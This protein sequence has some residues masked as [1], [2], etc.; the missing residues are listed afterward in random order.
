MSRF[1]WLPAYGC[2]TLMFAA[3]GVASAPACAAEQP[4]GMRFAIPAQSLST[5]LIAFGK[6]ANVQVLTAGQTV[7]ALRSHA[8]A[9]ALSM[10]AA[11]GQLLEGTG[12][13]FAFADARTVVIKP[14]KAAAT[15]GKSNPASSL[16][17]T[18]ATLLPPIQA[19]GLVGKD[20]GF[21]ADV[22]SGPTRTVS[23]PLD[24]PQS[25]GIV[26]QDLLQSEQVQ[27]IAEAIRNIAGVQ[28]YDGSSGLPIF[29]VRG[30]TTGNGMT[31][32]MPNNILGIGDFPPMIGVE[33]IEVLKGPEAILGDTSAYNN[34][35]GLIDVVLK[36][37]QAEPIH[38]LFYSIGPHGEKQLGVDLAGALNT[39]GSL[40]YR[41]I[42]NGDYADRTMQGMRGRR[43][44]YVAP[45]IG[46]SSPDTTLIVGA[47]WMMNHTPIPDHAILLRDTV[48]SASPPGILLDNP[49]DHTAIET[50]RLYYMLEHRFNEIWSFR[51]RAQ[52]VR[53]SIDSKYWYMDGMDP[54]GDLNATALDYRTSDAYYVLQNDVTASFGNSWMQHSLVL[55]VDYSRIQLGGGEYA[56]SNGGAGMSY[57]IFSSGPLAPAASALS[58]DDYA[59]GYFSG[60]PWTTETGLFIQDQIALG[61]QWEALLAWRRTGYELQTTYPDGSPW[62][63]HKVQWVPN[64]GLVYK[65]TPEVS[66]YANTS[67]GFQPDTGL[68][69]DNHPLAPA[70]SRQIEI[71]TKMNLFQ[72][73]A[74]LTVAAY[75]IMLNNSADLISLQP[76]YYFITGPGQSNKGIEVEFNGRILPGWDLSAA[77]TNA[78]IHNNDGTPPL[79]ASRQRF[80]LW[81]SYTLQQ[82][83][84]RGFGV[85]L[86]VLARSRSLGIMSGDFNDYVSIAGGDGTDYISIPGQASVSANVFYRAPR[87]S[88]TLGVKNLLDRNLY[89]PQFDETFVPLRNHRS[90]LLSGTYSF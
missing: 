87:W 14:G 84:L 81:S 71:G 22:S 90:F 31:D 65:L 21:M 32:G 88:V 36:K 89:G 8:V 83:A 37:P 5:A 27:T 29:D 18:R 6:Q 44:R 47:S 10:Q 13:V 72:D 53:E 67:N 69:K 46:W 85:G 79:G 45:S 55:G 33:R 64:F 66:I 80:N 82:G 43:N 4:V 54:A 58:A 60:N 38:Q 86:G 62:N 35:G 41:L 63:P 70:L 9:G 3:G 1:A 48:S 11:L 24:V 57:N 78:V 74:R 7:E 2:L 52:Y 49:D 25:V 15:G 73:R 56:L 17:Q 34:F 12:M 68:G 51:S 76:P 50:R 20:E 23:D 19:I 59:E 28:Y 39:S 61:T 42:A 75:R 30:F 77:F 40:S 16:D 26:T